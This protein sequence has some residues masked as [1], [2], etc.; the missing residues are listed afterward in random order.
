MKSLERV[1]KISKVLYVLSYIV[2]VC[3]IVGLISGFIGS[4]CV[5]IWGNSPEVIEY[6]ESINES[7]TIIRKVLCIC[8]CVTI[9]CA[10]MIALYYY[11]KRFYK[12]ELKTGTPYNQSVVK[13][14]R[15]IG[16]L[17]LILPLLSTII[18]STIMFC[19]NVDL[20]MSNL[21]SIMLGIVYIILS[22]VIE[23]GID[24]KKK[25]D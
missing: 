24:K 14:M 11:V 19:F 16:I 3:S 17:H 25:N 23:C 15:F 1:Q 22:Y 8:I 6:L 2:F 12:N 13:E 9:E 4:I 18:V 7:T 21:S 5:G 20:S 10:F